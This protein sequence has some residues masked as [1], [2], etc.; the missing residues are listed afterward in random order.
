MV[1]GDAVK[2]LTP[3]LQDWMRNDAPKK[4]V[5]RRTKASFKKFLINGTRT[6]ATR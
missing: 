6:A 5:I 1:V 4:T 2:V 3:A